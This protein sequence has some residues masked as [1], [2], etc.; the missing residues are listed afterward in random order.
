[1][2]IAIHETLRVRASVDAVWA[3]LLDPR[4]VATCLPG[5]SLE[6]IVDERTFAGSVRVTLGPITATYRGRL[7][8]AEV[9]E[10]ARLVRVEGEGR[11][12]GGSQARGSLSSRLRPLPGG[13]TE[14]VAEAR[15]DVTGRIVQVGRGMIESVSRELFL[16]FATAL[17]QRLETA[18]GAG[19]APGTAGAEP[20]TAPA[21]SSLRLLPL[22]L[23]ILGATVV[24]LVR[25]LLGRGGTSAP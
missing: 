8:L 4:Q 14:L 1:M 5:A 13:Q 22:L 17:R 12:T 6:R 9:D 16:Q 20:A 25:R 15:V 2:T 19:P 7:R 21:P 3:F 24:R 18:E 23:R 11:E 10:G